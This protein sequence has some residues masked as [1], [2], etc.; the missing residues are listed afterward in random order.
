[1]SLTIIGVLALL[2][3]IVLVVL[4]LATTVVPFS[5]GGLGVG[6]G[7]RFLWDRVRARRPR[8]LK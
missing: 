2:V 3:G 7:A 5:L 8:F 6:I 1:V 4:A